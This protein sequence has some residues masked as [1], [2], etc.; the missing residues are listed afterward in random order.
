VTG[1]VLLFLALFL[2][3]QGEAFLGISGMRP[4]GC[5][6]SSSGGTQVSHKRIL[7]QQAFCEINAAQKASFASGVIFVLW[8]KRRTHREQPMGFLPSEFF[9]R[10]I[11]DHARM[12]VQV[13]QAIIVFHKPLCMLT[14]SNPPA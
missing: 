4:K 8:G 11:N 1:H 5:L 13:R 2:H 9:S 3:V 14:M 10:S 7:I 6:S 12:R